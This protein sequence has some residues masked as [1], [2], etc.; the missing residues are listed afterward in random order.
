MKAFAD[1]LKK[2]KKLTLEQLIPILLLE[3]YG[4]LLAAAHGNRTTASTYSKQIRKLEDFF[5]VKLTQRG[6]NHIHLNKAGEELARIGREFFTG[7]ERFMLRHSNRNETY[8]IGAGE[9][10]LHWIVIPALSR[11][12]KLHLPYTFQLGNLQNADIAA[13]L[14]ERSLDFGLL[15]EENIRP[16]MKSAFM[17][18][19]S[20]GLYVPDA[21]L[22]GDKPVDW[23]WVVENLPLAFHLEGTYVQSE[24]EQVLASYKL[25]YDVRLRFDTFPN[26]MVALNTGCYAVLMVRYSKDQPVPSNCT[27]FSLPC[28]DHLNR[29]I[30]LA[31]NPRPLESV[32]E[33][34]Q[35]RR[36]LVDELKWGS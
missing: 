1:Y 35:V 18:T 29:N 6:N 27:I 20:Y 21:L 8:T 11:L 13:R 34:D 10:L 17:G 36:H 32:P 16:P 7:A 33:T 23:Q 22:P 12:E 5:E 2:R 25:N 4:T 28:L 31:W 24:F 9:S 14:T 30:H 3:E 15:R 26:A 19:V